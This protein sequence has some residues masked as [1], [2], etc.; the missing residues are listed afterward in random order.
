MKTKTTGGRF[1]IWRN[2]FEIDVEATLRWK[3]E[4]AE[5]GSLCIEGGW[6]LDSIEAEDEA[7]NAYDLNFEEEEEA[8]SLFPPL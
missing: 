2:D 3:W 5:A 1:T 8:I 7:G 6:F 4:S